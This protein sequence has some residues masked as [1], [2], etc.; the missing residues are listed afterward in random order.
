MV[1]SVTSDQEMLQVSTPKVT[2]RAFTEE[3][4]PATSLSAKGMLAYSAPYAGILFF[5]TPMLTVL[6]GMYTTY[7][8]LELTAVAFAIFTMRIF[9]GITDPVVGYLADRHRAAGGSRKSW[10]SVGS[11]GM[12]VACY[13]LYVPPAEVTLTYFLTWSLVYYLSLT[14]FQIPHAIWGSELTTEYHQRAQVFGV[15]SVLGELGS[16]MFVFLPLL[17]MYGKGEYTPDLLK[18][19]VLIG[20]ILTVAC[21]GWMHWRAPAGVMVT[22]TGKDSLKLFVESLWNNKPLRIYYLASLFVNLNTG[23]WF[24]LLFLYLDAYLDLGSEI[25][26]MFSLGSIALVL[27]TPLWLKLVEKT[28]KHFM[29]MSGLLLHCL[30]MLA[31]L[32]VEPSTV[33]WIP[34]CLI[35]VAHLA[36]ASTNVAAP[37]ILGD[38]VDYGKLAFGKDRG[39]TYFAINNFLGKVALGM[40][41]GLALGLAGLFGFDP[42]NDIHS[43]SAVWG[44]NSDLS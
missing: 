4:N 14:I 43:D 41:G 29:W 8:G 11:T 24:G 10:V 3:E 40:G 23:M 30:Q 25:A 6:P 39:A 1:Q 5:M 7:F 44:L 42:A 13:F 27:S 26:L 19:A 9:D 18:D 38:I 28:S 15:R 32:F 37:S 33:W 31:M 17:P 20:S 34:L 16:L 2:S 35:M 22:V 36:I 21:L 12:I